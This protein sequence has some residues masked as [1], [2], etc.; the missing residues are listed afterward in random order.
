MNAFTQASSN[1][2]FTEPKCSVRAGNKHKMKWILCLRKCIAIRSI[3]H[4]AR[5]VKCISFAS[6]HCIEMNSLW[7]GFGS[8]GSDSHLR[9]NKKSKPCSQFTILLSLPTQEFHTFHRSVVQCSVHKCV[10]RDGTLKSYLFRNFLCFGVLGPVLRLDF[11]VLKRWN[12]DGI[13]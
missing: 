7:V 4:P 12:C 13:E 5:Y 9:A 10:L 11:F 3:S 6:L 2:Q 1:L 8:D